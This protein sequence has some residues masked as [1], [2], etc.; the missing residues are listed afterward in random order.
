MIGIYH[1]RDG[2]ALRRE[3]DVLIDNDMRKGTNF[4]CPMPFGRSPS[5]VRVYAR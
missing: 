4:S 1:F 2:A 5:R 3:I